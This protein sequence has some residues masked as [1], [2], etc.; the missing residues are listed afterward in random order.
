ME[1]AFFTKAKQAGLTDEE[2]KTSPASYA[3]TIHR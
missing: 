1:E 2:A 3:D